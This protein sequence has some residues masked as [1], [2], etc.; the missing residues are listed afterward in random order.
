MED[1]FKAFRRN[2]WARIGNRHHD[3]RPVKL[4]VNEL[5]STGSS[6]LTKELSETELDAIYSA[7]DTDSSGPEGLDRE[8]FMKFL[9]DFGRESKV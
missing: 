8:E 1:L 9:K 3:I 5:Q 6:V 2:T 4:C 7:S